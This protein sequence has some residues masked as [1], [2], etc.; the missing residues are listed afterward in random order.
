MDEAQAPHDGPKPAL[1]GLPQV[2]AGYMP[3]GWKLRGMGHRD[4]PPEVHAARPTTRALL[5]ARSGGPLPDAYLGLAQWV[6][7]MADQHQT[8]ICDGEAWAYAINARCGAIGRPIGR[9]AAACIYNLTKVVERSSPAYRLADDGASAVDTI[10]ALQTYGAAPLS[11]WNVDPDLPGFTE[12]QLLAEPDLDLIIDCSEFEL[13]GQYQVVPN[14]ATVGDDVCHALV[15][16]YS[17][18][19]GFDVTPTYDGYR[20]GKDDDGVDLVIPAPA[21]AVRGRHYN[22][23]LGYRTIAGKRQF[24]VANSWGTGWGN[25]GWAW[26]DE[27]F[28]QSMFQLIAVVANQA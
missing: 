6:T 22:A 3:D 7:W 2:A 8:S 25:F 24:L 19:G 15:N 14:E 20:G 11:V 10:T 26:V 16:D 17:L 23:V 27:A 13:V 5:G 28:L 21:G 4:D 18:V 12:D 9:I 1:V